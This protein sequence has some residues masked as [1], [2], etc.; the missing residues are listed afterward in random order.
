MIE[1][2]VG[3]STNQRPTHSVG[4]GG[5]TS[6]QN[7]RNNK[8]QTTMA[9]AGGTTHEKKNKGDGRNN[10][11]EGTAA[12]VPDGKHKRTKTF[13]QEIQPNTMSRGRKQVATVERHT[14]GVH[15]VD[16]TQK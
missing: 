16:L 6:D 1:Y 5:Q 10:R 3:R 9:I 11:G 14:E 12:P 7:Q 2:F 4:C 8:F 15:T 13:V